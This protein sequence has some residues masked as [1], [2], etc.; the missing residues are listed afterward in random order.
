MKLEEYESS[1]ELRDDGKILITVY[2]KTSLGL[3]P[4]NREVIDTRNDIARDALIELGWTPPKNE[5]ALIERGDQSEVLKLLVEAYEI[6]SKYLYTE[7][8]DVEMIERAHKLLYQA[9]E[10]IRNERSQL[11]SGGKNNDE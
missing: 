5:K 11:N 7:P 10:K 6:V 4:T 8:I 2:K 3:Q 1:M 9:V